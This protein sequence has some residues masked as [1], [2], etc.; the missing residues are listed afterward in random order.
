MEHRRS[1]LAAGVLGLALML[2]SAASMAFVTVGFS[3]NIAPPVLPV[4]EQPVIP[5]AGYIWV[6]GYWAYSD[7]GYYWVPGTWVL[8]PRVGL[9]WTPGY[10]GW[11]DGF[12]VWNQGYWGPEV[13]FYGGVNYGFG[14]TG[15]GYA[16][17]YWDH[18][19]FFYNRSVNNV[20]NVHI[21]NVY[22]KTVINNVTVNRVS[23]NGGT[24]GIQSRPTSEQMAAARG[25]H[26]QPVAAQMQQE[27][28]AARDP[29]LR[30]SFN[31]GRPPVAATSHAGAFSGHGVIAAR[32]APTGH[33]GPPEQSQELRAHANGEHP[34]APMS[35]SRHAPSGAPS[36]MAPEVN[37]A[38]PPAPMHQH[39][40]PQNEYRA[41][42]PAPT[43]Q[44]A[45]P[46]NEFRAIP[47]RH[48]GAAPAPREA[49]PSARPQGQPSPHEQPH[50]QHRPNEP[51]H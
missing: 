44:H 26:V 24:G 23:Y 9:L 21:T 1:R 42:P 5:A 40:P 2:A 41:M 18:D 51:H 32:N 25:P 33:M 35:P 16:G 20:E 31:H 34:Q 37:H 29:Q 7:D 47:E 45:P 17:G 27:H 14:Y 3:I 10:W 49:Y 4:Y 46:Q 48:G 30:N 22:N 38:P 13:G 12:Y 19:R 15:V 8:P 6:P 36:G 43:Y 11:N 50:E 39:A 28:A